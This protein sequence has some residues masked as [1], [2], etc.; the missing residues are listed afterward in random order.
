MQINAQKRFFILLGILISAGFLWAA[1]YNLNPSAL[2]VHLR[3]VQISWLLAG[4]LSFYVSMVLI[5][6]RWQ[7][8]LRAIKQVPLRYLSGLMAICYM[9]NNV[10]PLRAGEVLRVVLL[11]RDYGIAL[12]RSTTTIFI[13]RVFDGMVMLGFIVVPLLF[14][15]IPSSELRMAVNV[16][17]P[18]F[19]MAFVSFFVLALKPGALR[20]FVQSVARFLP[21]KLGSVA[22]RLGEDVLSGLEALR[23]PA[24]VF[25]ALLSALLSW[26][27]NALVYWLVS[28]AFGL[29]VSFPVMMTIVGVVNLASA[30]PVSPGQIGV[31]E[32]LVSRVLI[33]VGVGEALALAYALVVHVV[34]WL[35]PTLLGFVLL[36]QRGMGWYSIVHAAEL[37]RSTAG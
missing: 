26:F 32:F 4:V 8:L 25:G 1:F 3:A 34:I 2:F 6:L 30:L 7:Y 36:A 33:G 11:Y 16:A 27:F 29:Q 9:G 20:W 10:Y 18:L 23:S 15:D 37:E 22:L 24:H 31:F 17:A 28:F 14:I 19:L 12:G 13:E 35:P 5:A 21:G